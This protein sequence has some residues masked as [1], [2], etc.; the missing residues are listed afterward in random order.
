MGALPGVL[1]ALWLRLLGNMAEASVL[2]SKASL[3][4]VVR[5]EDLLA[6]PVRTAL[7]ILSPGR[8]DPTVAATLQT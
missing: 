5:Y 3:V 1:R 7:E 6:N 8:D 2:A 4:E